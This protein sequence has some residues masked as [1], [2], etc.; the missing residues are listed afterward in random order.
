MDCRA[1]GAPQFADFGLSPTLC[2]MV[3]DFRNG[4]LLTG[5]PI[6]KQSQALALLR[7]CGLRAVDIDIF[8]CHPTSDAHRFEVDINAVR[9]LIEKGV[10]VG[11]T[12]SNIRDIVEAI[13]FPRIGILEVPPICLSNRTLE[14]VREIRDLAEEVCRHVSSYPDESLPKICASHPFSVTSYLDSVRLEQELDY[15]TYKARL[16]VLWDGGTAHEAACSLL[17][18]GVVSLPFYAREHARPVDL[19]ADMMYWASSGIPILIERGAFDF[20]LANKQ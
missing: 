10:V 14:M 13:N 6:P 19:E 8:G 16:F 17:A 18:N 15:I 20:I 3:N 11:G 5:A 9:L 12:C 7:E 1:T 2:K 4:G